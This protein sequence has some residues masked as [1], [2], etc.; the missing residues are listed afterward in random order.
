[1]ILA[2]GD[3]GPDVDAMA[4]ALLAAH[5]VEDADLSNPIHL[6]Q[7]AA[8]LG[9]EPQTLLARAASTDVQAQLAANTAE[10]QQFGIMGSPTYIVDGDPFYGQDRLEM[11][12]LALGKPFQLS[13]WANPMVKQP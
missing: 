4:H 13:T 9:Q 3:R 8:Q 10:A 1:M 7:V 2:L 6:A 12:E 5:W 11:V